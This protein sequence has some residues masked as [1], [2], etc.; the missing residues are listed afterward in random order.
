L[1]RSLSAGQEPEDILNQVLPDEQV[2]VLSEESLAF[3]C[4]CNQ[5]RVE[6][7]VAMLGR[8]E[9]LE[10]IADG[11]SAEVRCDFCGE[12][13]VV[14]VEGLCVLVDELDERSN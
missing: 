13:Y 3:S 12:D 11:Q 2:R 6:R 5:G 10:M 4:A 9:L 7:G 1:A 14:T 8:D